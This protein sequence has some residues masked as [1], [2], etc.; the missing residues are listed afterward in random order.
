MSASSSSTAAEWM[1][2]EGNGGE[3]GCEGWA[4][5]GEQRD[6]AAGAVASTWAVDGVG[7]DMTAGV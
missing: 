3:G 6:E 7:R 4:S 2:G 1:A 5:N